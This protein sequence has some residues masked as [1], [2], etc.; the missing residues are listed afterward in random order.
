MTNS[1]MFPSPLQE[2]N[3]LLRERISSSDGSRFESADFAQSRHPGGSFA[4]DA[5]A[6]G[7]VLRF[8]SCADSQSAPRASG[9][10]Q[11]ADQPALW[12]SA[13]LNAVIEQNS[14]RACR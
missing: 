3:S 13:D 8:V 14:P 12:K 6:R 7:P 4:V 1:M 2:S 5:S 9:F 11:G 10:P